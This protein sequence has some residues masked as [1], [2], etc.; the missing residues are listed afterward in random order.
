[1]IISIQFDWKINRAIRMN[2]IP[3]C[4]SL[5]KETTLCN[6]LTHARQMAMMFRWGFRNG[7]LEECVPM[8]Y[9]AI[10]M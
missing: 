7:C 10:P 2:P 8:N 1:M 3:N 9:A 4:S 5:L 6:W